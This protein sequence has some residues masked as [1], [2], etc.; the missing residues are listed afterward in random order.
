MNSRDCDLTV[1]TFELDGHKFALPLT[2]VDRLVQAVALTELEHAPGVIL[3]V[4]NV[5]GSLV[6]VADPGFRFGR[7][8]RRAVDPDDLLILARTPNHPVA[9]LVDSVEGVQ[10]VSREQIAAA[11]CWYEQSASTHKLLMDPDGLIIIFDLAELL[12]AEDE[13][14]LEKSIVRIAGMNHAS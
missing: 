11:P 3:G 9:L 5:H 10:A 1:L 8:R 6:A 12:T 7:P 2:S 13:R 4:I 14:A